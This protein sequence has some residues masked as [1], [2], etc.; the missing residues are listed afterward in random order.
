MDV[1]LTSLYVKYL[2]CKVFLKSIIH[3]VNNS[4]KIIIENS[5]KNIYVI[6][7]MKNILF[8]LCSESEY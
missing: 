3:A 8:S 6:V 4:L 7:W 5:R 1:S 2:F